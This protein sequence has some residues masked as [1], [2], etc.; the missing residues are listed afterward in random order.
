MYILGKLKMMKKVMR[1]INKYTFLGGKITIQKELFFLNVKIYTTL[2][3][4]I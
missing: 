3:N 4:Y 1:M 2:L